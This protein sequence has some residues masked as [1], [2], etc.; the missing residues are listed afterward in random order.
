VRRHI[1][2]GFALGH[3]RK[4]DIVHHRHHG[5][6]ATGHIAPQSVRRSCWSDRDRLRLPIHLRDDVV[7]SRAEKRVA[8][9]VSGSEQAGISGLCRLVLVR[10]TELIG[11]AWNYAVDGL[12]QRALSTLA[13][14]L[15]VLRNLGCLRSVFLVDDVGRACGGGLPWERGS[16]VAHESYC[17]FGNGLEA[18][19][20][21]DG[22]GCWCLQQVSCRTDAKGYDLC[23]LTHVGS[24]EL[25]I[26]VVVV[27]GKPRQLQADERGLGFEA[28]R[29]DGFGTG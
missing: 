28:W 8:V 19:I 7:Y 24:G 4:C 2:S 17:I 13:A 26:D 1:D 23:S 15:D 3:R 16:I 20:L 5:L 27:A 18:A 11:S 22:S 25:M 14:D 29:A 10:K 21:D 12:P 9:G 6:A